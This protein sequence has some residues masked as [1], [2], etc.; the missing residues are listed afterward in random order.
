M[1]FGHVPA[2]L[3]DLCW[4]KVAALRSPQSDHGRASKIVQCSGSGNGFTGGH[5]L[6]QAGVV[7]PLVVELLVHL[8]GFGYAAILNLGLLRRPQQPIRYL[9]D[10]KPAPLKK[11]KKSDQ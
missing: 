10:S 1:S 9:V 7:V 4:G 6:G 5:A 11:Q 3:V 2:D 8:N